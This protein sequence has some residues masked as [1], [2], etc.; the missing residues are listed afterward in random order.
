[1]DIFKL[2]NKYHLFTLDMICVHATKPHSHVVCAFVEILHT[3]VMMSIIL[4]S[5][6]AY[7]MHI[8]Y[9]HACMYISMLFTSATDQKV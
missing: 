5:P 9:M 4:S 7:V 1:M 6:D 3:V 2:N 8:M